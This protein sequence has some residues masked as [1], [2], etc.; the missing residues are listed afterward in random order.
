MKLIIAGGRD[1]TDYDLL[2][3][4]TLP[5][6][7]R[8]PDLEIVSGCARGADL[9]GERFAEEHGLNIIRFRPDWEGHGRSAGYIRN[10]EMAQNADACVC[11]WDGKSKGTGHMI[12]LA[13]SMGLRTKIVSY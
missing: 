5:I 2:L 13:K 1:F 4:A 12:Q 10:R 8:V 3:K 11:F 9:L 7:A 6:L